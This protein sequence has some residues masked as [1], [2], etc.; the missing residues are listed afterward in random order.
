MSAMWTRLKLWYMGLTNASKAALV[1]AWWTF[2]GSWAVTLLGWLAD[3]QRWVDDWTGDRP[4]PFPSVSPLGKAFA[5]G[6]V[7]AVAGLANYVWRRFRPAPQYP[8][9]PPGA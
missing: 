8:G 2:S 3:V 5:S 9:S 4:S 6:L 1:T 7:A